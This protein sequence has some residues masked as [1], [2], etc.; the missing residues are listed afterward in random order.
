MLGVELAQRLE[1]AGVGVD[2]PG[3]LVHRAQHAGEHVDRGGVHRRDEALQ[4]LLGLGGHVD[5]VALRLAGDPPHLAGEV[6]AADDL[7]ADLARH[8]RPVAEDAALG[9]V[10]RERGLLGDEPDE[11]LGVGRHPLAAVA[12]Q[13]LARR[14]RA[15]DDD[16]VPA[17]VAAVLLLPG[18]PRPVA[19]LRPAGDAVE[20]PQQRLLRLGVGG[21]PHQAHGDEQRVV[22]AG[23]PARELLA[24]RRQRLDL[25]RVGGAGVGEPPVDEP[26]L[27]HA[28]RVDEDDE[29][30]VARVGQ[31]PV[32]EGAAGGRGQV[33]R[34]RIGV[35]RGLHGA[36]PARGARG[37]FDERRRG[38]NPPYPAV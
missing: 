31:D 28:R 16:A 4:V 33:A 6:R 15:P 23:Q 22:P 37:A 17:A 14:G 20:Q 24:A 21:L 5:R 8:L 27:E 19:Q 30:A 36:P 32:G 26:A 9:A 34:D 35:G 1:P 18:G 12:D 25:P 13:Q 11:V 2:L 29:G 10:E 3:A 7:V 38:V